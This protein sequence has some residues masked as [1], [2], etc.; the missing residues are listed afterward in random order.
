VFLRGLM[1][2]SRH[3]GAFPD[4]FRQHIGDAELALPD[5]PGNGVLHRSRSP[6]RVE[7]MVE[8]YRAALLARGFAP[9]YRLFA[10]SLGAMVA[11]AWAHRHPHEVDGCVLINTSLR[12]FNPFYRRLR[13][14]NYPCLARLAIGIGNALAQERL[15]LRLTSSRADMHGDILQAWAAYR[16]EYPVSRRNT[17]SQLLAA[18]S[19]RA[20]EQR[21][22]VPM[23]VLAS[24]ADRL[25]DPA[26]SQNIAQRWGTH[27]AMHPQAGHDLPLDDGE[28][29]AMQ[30]RGWLHRN[31]DGMK[32]ASG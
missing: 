15:I 13:W 18:A 2:E 9:P 3:W 14:Y 8:C 4:L 20:P 23:L 29:V 7:Q 26:C 31:R 24:S 32:Y 19:Y 16:R 1:R 27:F 10:L 17:L 22:P 11:V 5:L 25:V 30:V 28:W 21:P 12:P 6:A